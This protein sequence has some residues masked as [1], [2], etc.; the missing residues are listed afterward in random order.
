M[1]SSTYPDSSFLVSLVCEDTKSEDARG[2]MSRASEPLLFTPLH[3][4]ESRNALRNAAGRGD[5]TEADR[6]VAF[7]Q[8]EADLREGVLVHLPVNWTDV[9]R[10]ADELSEKHAGTDGQR[11]VDLLHVAIA[12]ESSAKTF[13]S[14]DTRQRRLAKAAGLKVS[15]EFCHTATPAAGR[16]NPAPAARPAAYGFKAATFSVITASAFASDRAS[17]GLLTGGFGL[18]FQNAPANRGH[19][20]RISWAR[21]LSVASRWR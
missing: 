7:R 13:L 18:T 19:S 14:F 12:L 21:A 1:D 16:R 4:V 6:R 10:R 2:F 3:R 20:P 9:F 15:L 8:I 5:I 17:A 11:T